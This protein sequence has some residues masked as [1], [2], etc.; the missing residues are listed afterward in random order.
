MPPSEPPAVIACNILIKKLCA[1]RRLPDAERVLDALKASGAADA[2]S[3]NT[4]V[5][6]YCRDGRLADAERVLEVAKASG[7]ANVVT[8]TALINGYCRS[9]RLADALSLIAS[10]PV[11]PDTYTYNTVLKGLCGAKQ[12]EEADELMEEMIRNDCH[13]N[14]VTFATQIRSFCQNRSEERRVGKECLL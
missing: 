6:G 10:M 1:Q 3:H 4:L 8:Y 11:A 2:V 9:G 5:A 14:E 13:P 7:A 12:W